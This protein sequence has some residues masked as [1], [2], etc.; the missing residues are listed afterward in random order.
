MKCAID[1]GYRHID[2][3]C[4]YLN[5]GEVGKAIREKI[6]EGVVSRE[7]I[8]V[9]TKLWPTFYEPESVVKACKRSL[10]LLGLEYIDLFLIHCPFALKYYADDVYTPTDSNGKWET[11]DRDYVDVWKKLEEC[12]K[13]GY[14]RSIGLSNFN[15]VQIQRVLDAATIKPVVNQVE[16]SLQIN[17]KPLINFCKEHD[18]LV[19]GYCPLG[20]PDPIAKKPVF[21]YHDDILDVARK[22]WKSPA[23]VALRYLVELGVV[24]LPKSSHRKRIEENIDIFGFKL[25]DTDMKLLDKFNTGERTVEFTEA[26]NNINYPF[27]HEF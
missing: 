18:I 2:T 5:E 17:Q 10:D 26:A 16:C 19:T 3:A 22:Y 13:L 14:V 6:A 4:F 7:D 12:V 11:T 8:F 27:H 24:P 15:S 21:L 25:T 20:R 23:Q 9:T 1:I